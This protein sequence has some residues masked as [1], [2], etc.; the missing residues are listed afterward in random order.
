[1]FACGAISWLNQ[2]LW[3]KSLIHIALAFLAGIQPI[4]NTGLKILR[5]LR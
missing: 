2:N 4:H 1:L 5:I 3:G